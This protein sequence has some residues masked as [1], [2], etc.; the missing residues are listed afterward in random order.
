MISKLLIEVTSLRK[1]IWPPFN[2]KIK[3]LIRRKKVVAACD[4]SLKNRVMG[5]Y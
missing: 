3:E 1:E 5:T 2:N 4:A